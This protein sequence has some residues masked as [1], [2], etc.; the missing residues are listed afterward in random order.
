MLSVGLLIFPN[1]RNNGVFDEEDLIF[2]RKQL[3][4]FLDESAKEN[5]F[6]R[7]NVIAI[8]YSNGAEYCSQSLIHY[9]ACIKRGNP[10]LSMVPKGME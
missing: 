6:D 1:S 7:G 10:S 4:T 8:G 5:G 3:Y 2:R 9:G